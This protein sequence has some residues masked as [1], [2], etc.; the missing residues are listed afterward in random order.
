MLD[1]SERKCRLQFDIGLSIP[2][3]IISKAKHLKDSLPSRSKVI[4]LKNISPVAYIN[5]CV[6]SM[7]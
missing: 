2:E 5:V 3:E 7:S 6:Y 1:P 4:K